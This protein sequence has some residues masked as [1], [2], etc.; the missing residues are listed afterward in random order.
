MRGWRDDRRGF[1]VCQTDGQRDR[2]G[3]DVTVLALRLT[4]RG[5]INHQLRQPLVPR[6]ND[7]VQIEAAIIG[8]IKN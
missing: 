3:P 6:A 7:V 2:W 8:I 1:R 5:G 4:S